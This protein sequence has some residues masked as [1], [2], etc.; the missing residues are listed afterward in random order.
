MSAGVIAGETVVGKW[1]L[2]ETMAGE[3]YLRRK[4]RIT[5]VIQSLL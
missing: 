4:L 2:G 5:I 1:V 3:M